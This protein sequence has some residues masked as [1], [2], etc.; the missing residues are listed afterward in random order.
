VILDEHLKVVGTPKR[1]NLRERINDAKNSREWLLSLFDFCGTNPAADAKVTLAIDAPLG[2]S[3]E[4]VKLVTSR[5]AGGSVDL[6]QTNQYL[7]RK[8]EQILFERKIAKPL[9][10][11]KDMIGSQATKAMHVVAKF[12]HH[13]QNRGVWTDEKC[14]TVIEVYPACCKK[15]ALAKRER[16]KIRLNDENGDIQDAATCAV[17]A[18]LFQTEQ[19]ELQPPGADV[20]DN[21]GWI[22]LPKDLFT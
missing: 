7:Y 3:T 22:W 9:S 18:H 16:E 1:G 20:P 21:E 11:V 2:F 17:I 6:S 8:T 15:S 4:F 19:G 12:A 5:K 14:M 10:A 13:L